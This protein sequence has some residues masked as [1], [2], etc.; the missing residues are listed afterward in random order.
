MYCQLSTRQRLFYRAIKNKISIEDLFKSHYSTTAQT[1]TNNLMNLVMQFRKVC[2]YICYSNQL[3]KIFSIS[4]IVEQTKIQFWSNQR[5]FL[6]QISLL[7][8]ISFKDLFKSHSSTTSYTNDLMNLIMQFRKVSSSFA[9]QYLVQEFSTYLQHLL[10]KLGVKIVLLETNLNLYLV[11]K[12][13]LYRLKYV[14]ISLSSSIFFL[15]IL[16]LSILPYYC[17]N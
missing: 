8:S 6:A 5:L 16:N 9:H 2:I 3:F 7:Y 12:G 13:F 15:L 14:V 10:I 17:E 4:Y 1:Q 11:K